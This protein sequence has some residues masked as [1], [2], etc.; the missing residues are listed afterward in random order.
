MVP[1]QERKPMADP[2]LS[3]PES[4]RL[5][6]GSYLLETGTRIPLSVITSVSTRNAAPGDGVYLQTIMPVAVNGRVVVPQGT[7]VVGKVSQ[8]VRPGKVKGKG[9]LAVRF[10]KLQF[11]DGRALDLTG[12]LGSVD[13]DTRGTVDKQE[14]ALKSES[15]A[16]RDAMVMAGTTVT[17]TALGTWVGDH[18]G[19]NAGIGAGAGAAAGL[20]AVLLTRG[21]DAVLHRGSTLDMVLQQ[22]L[23]IPPRR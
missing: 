1:G 4:R 21:P 18:S 7:Y 9:S 12:R 10:E 23:R 22:P 13:G 20:A 2:D 6:D 19:A 11:P 14:G 3:T 15:G 5:D 8:T 17:G 16:G